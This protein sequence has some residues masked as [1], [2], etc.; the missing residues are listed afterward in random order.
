[1]AR[2]L[3]IHDIGAGLILP[4]GIYILANHKKLESKPFIKIIGLYHN[5]RAFEKIEISK[6]SPNRLIFSTRG[7]FDMGNSN[8]KE[9]VDFN[10][11]KVPIQWIYSLKRFHNKNRELL[12]I[13]GS[14]HGQKSNIFF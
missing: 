11:R 14:P 6:R 9:F 5:F 10:H 12:W 7:I 13:R 8:L 4:G 3:I 2:K 1:M